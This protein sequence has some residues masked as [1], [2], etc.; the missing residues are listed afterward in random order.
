M[1]NKEDAFLFD[2]AGGQA[3]CEDKQWRKR[4]CESTSD[5]W[6][7]YHPG[8]MVLQ[9]L[10][11]LGY[12]GSKRGIY[13]V[14]GTSGQRP[15]AWGCSEGSAQHL[16]KQ[17]QNQYQQLSA[18]YSDR[19]EPGAEEM[20]QLLKHLP[21]KNEDLN[22]IPTTNMQNWVTHACNLSS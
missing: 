5:S 8:Q 6:E 20:A 9:D 12:P 13:T 22:S 4:Q 16:E 11:T 10:V 3:P 17:K 21:D 1:G 15:T 18:S 19:K 14:W 2:L 7:L